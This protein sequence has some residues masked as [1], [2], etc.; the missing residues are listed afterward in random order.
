MGLLASWLLSIVYCAEI[1]S[2]LYYFIVGK[3][4]LEF[5]TLILLGIILSGWFEALVGFG[6]HIHYL[7]VIT[8][9]LSNSLDGCNRTTNMYINYLKHIFIA[10][11]KNITQNVKYRCVVKHFHNQIHE[12]YDHNSTNHTWKIPRSKTFYQDIL[13]EV[14]NSFYT[15]T[16]GLRRQPESK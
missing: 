11:Y 2:Y 16:R 10:N 4:F 3:Y 6:K 9:K 7:L 1:L 5:T 13:M 14:F 12:L 8:L 15:F